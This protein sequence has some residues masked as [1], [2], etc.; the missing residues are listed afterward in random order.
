M[1]AIGLD[2][3]L[4]SAALAI[5]VAVWGSLLAVEESREEVGGPPIASTRVLASAPVF[6]PDGSHIA[7]TCRGSGGYGACVIAA[8]GG[9]SDR[10]AEIEGYPDAGPAF[11]PDGRIAFIGRHGDGDAVYVLDPRATADSDAELLVDLGADSTYPAFPAAGKRLA[12]V[13]LLDQG[14]YVH[15]IE[16]DGTGRR[17]VGPPGASEPA[18]SP[19]GRTIAFVRDVSRGERGS[20]ELFVMAIDGSGEKQLTDDAGNDNHHPAFAP[21]GR[22][23][24]FDRSQDGVGAGVFI[25]NSDG[26]GEKRL[27]PIGTEPAFSPDGRRIAFVRDGQIWVID[28]DGTGEKQLTVGAEAGSGVP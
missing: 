15:L 7:F 28:A 10:L 4:W 20:Y 26:T 23:I 6:S 14:S 22:T 16:A 11:T 12:F 21:D 5:S 24:A 8:D 1:G 25:V 17:H 27:V 3:R 9:E 19:D 2:V 18:L 13:S